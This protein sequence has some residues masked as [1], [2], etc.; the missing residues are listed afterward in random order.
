MILFE[1]VASYLLKKHFMKFLEIKSGNPDLM[2]FAATCGLLHD[3]TTK[4][5]H[6]WIMKIK[7][8]NGQDVIFDT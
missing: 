8:T 3:V 5:A 7:H 6:E 4:H 1:D 2:F